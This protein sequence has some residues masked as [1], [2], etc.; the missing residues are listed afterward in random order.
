MVY[1][2]RSRLLSRYGYS[3]LGVTWEVQNVNR[4]VAMHPGCLKRIVECSPNGPKKACGGFGQL[5]G[6]CATRTALAF[7]KLSCVIQNFLCEKI[8]LGLHPGC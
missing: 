8:Y 4:Q 5:F 6:L 2:S 7:G 1:S 3:T